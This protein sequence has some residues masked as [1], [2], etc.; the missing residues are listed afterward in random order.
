MDAEVL[1]KLDPVTF[2][3]PKSVC[4]G[5]PSL[6]VAAQQQT[7]EQLLVNVIIAFCFIKATF[8]LVIDPRPRTPDS[9]TNIRDTKHV[10]I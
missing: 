1:I 6:L 2:S 9:T 5:P 3:A 4:G 7:T 10:L 8:L